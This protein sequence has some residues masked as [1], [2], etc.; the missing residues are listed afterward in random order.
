MTNRKAVIVNGTEIILERRDIERVLSRVPIGEPDGCWEWT[1]PRHKTSYG[2]VNLWKNGRTYS[3]N[4]HRIVYMLLVDD[5][6]EDM[7]IDHL[8]RN[9]ICVNPQHHEVVTGP[10]NTRR[11]ATKTHCKRGHKF[12]EGSTRIDAA[13]ARQCRS[14]YEEVGRE[15]NRG[16]Y[17]ANKERYKASMEV[18]WAR[19]LGVDVGPNCGGFTRSGA[20]CVRPEGHEGRHYPRRSV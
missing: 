7:V 18:Y 2:R 17:H 3:V 16:Y 14:C 11:G 5:V 12:T 10:E 8:C 13:G 4:A 20:P 19:K 9:R 15:R 1:G 6:P